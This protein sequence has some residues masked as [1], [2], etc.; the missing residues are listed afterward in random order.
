MFS[1]GEDKSNTVLRADV[2]VN[3]DANLASRGFEDIK[4]RQCIIGTI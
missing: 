2:S 3:E 4:D 1:T